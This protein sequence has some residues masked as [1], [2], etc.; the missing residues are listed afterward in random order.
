M[1]STESTTAGLNTNAIIDGRYRVIKTVGEGGMG[2]VYLAEHTLIKRRV[3]VKVLHPELASDGKVVERFM[4]EARAAGTLGHPNIVESTDMGFMEGSIPYIV[5]EYLEGTLLTDEIYRLGSVPVRRAVK[6]AQQIASALNAAHAA[7]IIHRDLKAD[8]VF[9][10]DRGEMLDHVKVLDFGISKFLEAGDEKTRRG[11]IMGT[12]EFMA[13]EQITSPDSVDARSD[14]Y[15]L[16]VI[17]YEMLAGRRP[18]TNDD[19]RTLLHRIVHTDAPPIERP[20]VPRGLHDL[21]FKL[22]EKDPDERVQT[23]ADVEAVLD[24]YTTHGESGPVVMRRSQRLLSERPGTADDG[25]E[26]AMAIRGR[27]PTPVPARQ[28]QLLPLNPRETPWPGGRVQTPWPPEAAMSQHMAAAPKAKAPWILYALVGL[29]VIVGAIGLYIGLRR[30]APAPAPQAQLQPPAPAPA[31]AIP[32]PAAPQKVEVTIDAD[33]PGAR[34]VFRRRLANAPFTL[35]VSPTDIV[36]LVEVSAPG[37][38]TVRYWLTIDRPTRLNAKLPKGNGMTEATEE[39]TL[40]ALGE[41]D[42]AAPVAATE[43]TPAAKP[44]APTTASAAKPVAAAAATATVAKP[45]DKPVQVAKTETRPTP[46]KI[47]RAAATD[48]AADAPSAFE[49]ATANAMAA[50]VPVEAAPAPVTE[51]KPNNDL[52]EIAA[53]AGT[54][55]ETAADTK[56]AEAKP[57]VDPTLLDK[58]VV[59]SVMKK[60]RPAVVACYEQGKKSNSKLKGTVTVSM[61]VDAKGAISR[62]QVNSTLGN[63]VVAAC[64]LKAVKGWKFPARPGGKAAPASYKFALQ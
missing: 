48:G 2:T 15:A 32:A 18:F 58:S 3:A 12:P 38:R 1:A 33:V 37:R 11:M 49:T 41:A 63:P 51:P 43:E 21:V 6:I 25:N 55:T 64:I 9:L 44:A 30:E 28:S 20:E 17:L 29:G 26:I 42:I 35:Q 14:I 22:L 62:P 52:P 54:T 31:A 60:N 10:T 27:A 19:P 47:G 39:D 13:P 24:L 8:N 61:T 16:G 57:A 5:F 59:A 7:G 4:N 46:R 40:V 45:A 53:A 34:V 36:E 23:M 56:P 50:P